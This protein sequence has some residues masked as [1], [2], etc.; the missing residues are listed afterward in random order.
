MKKWIGILLIILL[1]SLDTKSQ[2]LTQT[3]L[4]PC[5]NKMYVVSFPLPISVI[6]VAIRNKAKSFTYKDAQNG[7]MS[8]WIVGI[9]STPCPVPV[10]AAATQTQVAASVAKS[11]A[12]VAATAAAAPPPP[13]SAR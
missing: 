13:S 3:Y 6:T 5:D 2:V 11:A 12:T 9:L 10:A 1:Y 4:D 7:T 8:Q